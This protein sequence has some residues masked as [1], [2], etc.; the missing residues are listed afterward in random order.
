MGYQVE[1]VNQIDLNPN[2]VAGIKYPFNAPGVFGVEYNSYERALSNLKVLLLTTK[3]ERYHQPDF[4]TDLLYIIFEPNVLELID[5][6]KEIITDP[7]D[8]WCPYIDINNIQ[9]DGI[10]NDSSLIHTIKVTID[11]SVI[12]VDDGNS[13]IKLF[14]NERGIIEIENGN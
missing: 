7:V 5:E 8:Y 11:F 12:G 4:G 13:T 2:T 6:V 14:A 10:Q 9:V 1:H 3:G